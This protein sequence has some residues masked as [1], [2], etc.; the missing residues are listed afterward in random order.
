MSPGAEQVAAGASARGWHGHPVFFP[1]NP[2]SPVLSG[3]VCVSWGRPSFAK[4]APK[5]LLSL[6]T[7]TLSCAC[8][9]LPGEAVDGCHQPLVVSRRRF[10]DH[11]PTPTAALGAEDPS[12]ALCPGPPGA[13]TNGGGG[14]PVACGHFCQACGQRG[15]FVS[16]WDPRETGTL[17][18][19]WSR[20]PR[21]LRMQR[22]PPSG[23]LSVQ[24]GPRPFSA[25]AGICLFFPFSLILTDSL[26]P[27]PPI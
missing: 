16:P 14:L 22:A 6:V 17:A 1:G 24:A 27:F 26:S 7:W 3:T 19:L 12:A 20:T 23:S 13:R 2:G 4:A 15:R 21:G 18:S 11:L 5:P 9:V 25:S 10:H 8:R